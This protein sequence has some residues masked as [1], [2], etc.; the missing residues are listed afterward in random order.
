MDVLVRIKAEW[1]A[2]GGGILLW[3]TPFNGLV[4]PRQEPQIKALL[5]N[6]RYTDSD[7]GPC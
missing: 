2:G 4:L 3:W 6:R 1:G 5:I 7:L